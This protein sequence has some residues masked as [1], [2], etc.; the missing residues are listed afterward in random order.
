MGS[1]ECEQSC[2]ERLRAAWGQSWPI[3]G[4][5]KDGKLPYGQA[6][7]WRAGRRGKGRSA[8][9]RPWEF[10]SSFSA[11]IL[12]SPELGNNSKKGEAPAIWVFVTLSLA[13]KQQWQEK[14]VWTWGTC[15]VWGRVVYLSVCGWGVRQGGPGANSS[16]LGSLEF[17]NKLL[18]PLNSCLSL[19][20][21]EAGAQHLLLSWAELIEEK[22]RRL[23]GDL[24]WGWW[25]SFFPSAHLC[26]ILPPGQATDRCTLRL[27]EPPPCRL[28]LTQ[29]SSRHRLYRSW[30][31]L[32]ETLP[33]S[34]K[35]KP[36]N[37]YSIECISLL[38]TV[39]L[40]IKFHLPSLQR[41]HQPP[42]LINH[43]PQLLLNVPSVSNKPLANRGRLF[44][45]L[46]GQEWIG[47]RSQ[48]SK[49]DAF[50][51]KD[52]GCGIKWGNLSMWALNRGEFG[53]ERERERERE[54][55]WPGVLYWKPVRQ[56]PMVGGGCEESGH[57]GPPLLLIPVWKY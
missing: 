25:K 16:G 54:R 40:S 19:L 38:L 49:C 34:S 9:S 27:S 13:L 24:S 41:R 21:Q 45:M 39:A 46:P 51:P 15:G 10:I 37:A 28:C 55:G 48:K 47:P 1:R 35:E 56:V 6:T 44:V 52:W 22:Q 57:P 5:I 29:I 50:L 4:A 7:G 36:S 14:A 20:F 2:L 31:S 12:G 26:H 30:I 11:W 53:Q 42:Y 18:L 33:D 8:H 43:R 17:R 23:E 3:L 32:V